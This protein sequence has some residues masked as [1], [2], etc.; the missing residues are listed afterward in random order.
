MEPAD[1][2]REVAVSTSYAYRHPA[3]TGAPAPVGRRSALLPLPA[4]RHRRRHLY[5]WQV[6]NGRLDR[7]LNPRCRQCAGLRY[8][9]QGIPGGGPHTEPWR[10][11]AVSDP[12][13]VA[14]EFPGSL[15]IPPE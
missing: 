6:I 11:R 13:M 15:V 8:L 9:T 4:C 7:D 1:D 3:L 2:G 14:S 10:P 5:P 12:R